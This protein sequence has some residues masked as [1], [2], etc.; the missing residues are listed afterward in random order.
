MSCV[1]VSAF[2]CMYLSVRVRACVRFIRYVTLSA[3]LLCYNQYN[4]KKI[5]LLVFLV[6][7]IRYVVK[8]CRLMSLTSSF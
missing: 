7:E 6:G 1:K 5:T 4:Q 3:T 2:Y 8:F